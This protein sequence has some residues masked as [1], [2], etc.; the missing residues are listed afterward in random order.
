M[1]KWLLIISSVIICTGCLLI[2]GADSLLQPYFSG[3]TINYNGYAYIGTVNS[4]NF[5]LFEL[6]DDRIIKKNT[7]RADD[8]EHYQFIDLILRQEG[9][10]LFVYLSSGRYLY[11]YDISDSTN[12]A[13]IKKIKDNSN[14][15]FFALSQNKDN[16][17][18]VGDKGTKLWNEDLQTINTFDVH[19][20]FAENIKF[21]QNGNY[22]FKILQNELDII[23]AFYRNVVTGRGIDVREDHVRNLYN[24]IYEGAIYLVD[25]FSL[26]KIYFDGSSQQFNHTS[27]SGYD[28]DGLD[29][30][31]YVY[32]SDGIG[33]VKIRKSDMKPVDWAYTTELGAGNGWAVGLQVMEDFSGEE[34]V[35][36]FNGSSL[37]AFDQDLNLIDFYNAGGGK[38]L[39]PPLFI[40]LDKNRGTPNSLVSVRGGGFGANEGLEIK[41]LD[42]CYIA[43]SDANGNFKTVVTVPESRAQI[44]DIKATG[45]ISGLTYSTTFNIE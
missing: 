36:V 34:I 25:D 33:I 10:R 5:E 28:V 39:L 1:K 26:K 29:G 6:S 19:S 23:D 45:K 44:T 32:F 38:I 4:G 2:P 41:F 27:N 11:K 22:I 14:D 3:E 37:L 35:V 31:S 17:V 8:L 24:D 9:S 42:N 30:S 13:L 40:S 15:Y 21:S 7:I 12:I 20:T 18:T 43:K 16:I